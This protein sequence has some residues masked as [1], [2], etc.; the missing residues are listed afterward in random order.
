MGRNFNSISCRY[1]SGNRLQ[2]MQKNAITR[3]ITTPKASL[4]ILVSK[5][6]TVNL[7]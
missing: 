5:Q 3:Y 7:I 1:L 2:L 4:L 6:N